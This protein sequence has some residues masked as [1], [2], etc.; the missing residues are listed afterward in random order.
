M[1]IKN[2]LLHTQVKYRYLNGLLKYCNKIFLLHYFPPFAVKQ[3]NLVMICWLKHFSHSKSFW[4]W[5]GH[6]WRERR[7]RRKVNAAT[8]DTLSHR[9]THFSHSVTHPLIF[10]CRLKQQ[11]NS[12][13]ITKL[14]RTS[15]GQREIITALRWCKHK[16]TQLL[17]ADLM[18][19]SKRSE[20]IMSVRYQTVI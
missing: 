5:R 19:P 14:L 13:L 3:V 20:V 1:F 9:F 17:R 7:W 8:S 11:T 12:S 10:S 16:I 2:C 18:M 15:G 6:R 4:K